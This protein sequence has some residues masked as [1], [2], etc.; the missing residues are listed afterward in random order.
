[1]AVI[2]FPDATTFTASCPALPQ[3]AKAI[4][5][6]DTDTFQRAVTVVCGGAGTIT[7]SPANQT[8]A[9]IGTVPDV[10]FTMPAGGI[11]PVQV[12]AVKATGT[13]ATLI[14]ALY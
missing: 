4:T 5:P 10:Q 11:V 9:N 7:V 6:S 1:M 3:G 2:S 14:V 13:A 8:A 12:K